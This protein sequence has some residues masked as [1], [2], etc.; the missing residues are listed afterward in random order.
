MGT[1]PGGSG[2]QGAASSMATIVTGDC[3]R[4][5]DF[6]APSDRLEYLPFLFWL[7]PALAPRVGVDLGAV[8]AEPAASRR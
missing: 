7:V 8:S 1:T 2:R 3:L 6:L 5:P 4:Q